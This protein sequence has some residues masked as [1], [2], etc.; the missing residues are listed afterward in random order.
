M[1]FE[2]VDGNAISPTIFSSP[3]PHRFGDFALVG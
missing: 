2:C 1:V 3:R